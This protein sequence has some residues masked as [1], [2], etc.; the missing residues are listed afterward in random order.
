MK[1]ARRDLL[2]GLGLAV[3]TTGGA[4]TLMACRRDGTEPPDR[5][6]VLVDV[7]NNVIVPAYN[8]S[9]TDV[10]ALEAS[11]NTLRDAPTADSLNAARTAWKKART[12]WK[13]TDAFVYFGPASDIAVTGGAIDSLADPAKVE[14]TAAGTDPIDATAVNKLGANQRGF[15]GIETLL[16]D[17]ARDDAAMLAA[18]GTAG[19]RRGTFAALIGAELQKRV[20]A[21][22]DG[23]T[24]GYATQLSTAGRGSTTFVTE[25]QGIDIVVNG[26]VSAAE[27]IITLHLAQPLGI[28]K[29]GTPK[30]ALVES[31]R[32]DWSIEDMKA[33]MSGIEAIYLGVRNGALGLPLADAVADRNPTA[34]SDM[35]KDVTAAK[36]ALEA[37]PGPLRTAIV[38]R[39]DPVVAAHV[40]CR[41]VKRAL[42]TEVAAALGTSLGFT[43][44]DGD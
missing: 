16:F 1:L 34:D 26:L 43:V 33:A 29:D 3:A 42:A 19:S 6:K 7:T 20:T 35:K 36:A 18:F 23:W 2:I 13:F 5:G 41:E 4:R 9:V 44:T 11:L 8:D 30:P 27:I 21:V 10:T 14:E 17:P 40:A 37:I 25:H 28:D 24:G 38:D 39:R 32:A 15:A 31:P 22:R 12:T